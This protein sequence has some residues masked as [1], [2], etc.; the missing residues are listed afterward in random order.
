MGQGVRHS[1]P[2]RHG[3]LPCGHGGRRGEP[4]VVCYGVASSSP[5]AITGSACHAVAHLHRIGPRQAHA[6]P[7]QCW[8]A[9]AVAEALPCLLARVE[10]HRIRVAATMACAHVMWYGH[11]HGACLT[12]SSS[13]RCTSM[14]NRKWS[15][16]A[17][18]VTPLATTPPHSCC[19]PQ[20]PSPHRTTHP[21][22]LHPGLRVTLRAY[23]TSPFTIEAQRQPAK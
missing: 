15:T 9:G 1:A 18:E 3:V 8:A 23:Q 21:Q 12:S 2:G 10:P 20:P 14:L 11:P 13:N 6:R 22:H 4:H 19:C 7:G 16:A 5:D 17:Y